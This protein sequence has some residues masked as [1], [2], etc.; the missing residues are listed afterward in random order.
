MS[1]I[2]DIKNREILDSRGMPTVEVDIITENGV[3]ATY[4]VPSGASTG[5][6]EALEL[7]D[8]DERFHGK[9]VLKALK[10]INEII[11][12][13]LIGMDVSSQKEIDEKLIEL[14]GTSN[15]SNLG[16]NATLA[17]SIASLKAASLENEKE[18]YEYLNKRKKKIPYA[19]FNVVNGGQHAFNNL[20]IQEFMI[21]PK[22]DTFKEIVKVASEIFHSLK[23]IMEEKNM[24]TS[25]GDEGGFAP[26][27]DK[28]EDALKLIVDA[29]NTSG[30]IPG[31]NVFIAMDIAASSFYDKESN[32]YK[33]EDTLKTTDELLEYY[34][35]IV[36]KY[37]I[38]SIEDPFDENDIE[39]F[40]KITSSLGKHLMIV[41]DDLF[42]T[43]KELLQKGIEGKWA[44][45]ILIKPNQIGT[46]YEMLETIALAKKNG[47]N[48]IMSHRSGETNDTFIAD[49]AVALSIPYIKTG[50]VSR[51]ERVCKYNRLMRIEEDIK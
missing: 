20:D 31:K 15:K 38:I 30:Y 37:P 33:F 27:L 51:G 9:G 2:I 42:V 22:F 1:K 5:S 6:K 49:A 41:G 45:A 28:N 48:L 23:K 29:I 19:M 36:K 43:N 26:S 24:S 10:N 44:N 35:D 12:P 13:S 16:A 14:D 3:K 39:G 18:I 25:V 21:V 17:V 47:F 46:F 11:K 4:S 7:R 8:K 50:S 32:A 40:I 34:K